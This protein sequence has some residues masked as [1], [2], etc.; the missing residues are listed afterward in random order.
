MLGLV[1]TS[2]VQSEEMDGSELPDRACRDG[3]KLGGTAVQRQSGYPLENFQSYGG[4]AVQQD[5]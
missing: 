1:C 3:S 2:R 5:L 4:T